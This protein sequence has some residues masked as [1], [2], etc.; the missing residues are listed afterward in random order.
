MAPFPTT[1]ILDM[2]RFF[3]P[4]LALSFGL[5]A[6]TPDADVDPVTD[7]DEPVVTD[8]E[9]IQP[10]APAVDVQGTIDALDGGIL[11]LAPSAAL[12]NING[13]IAQLDGMDGADDVVEGLEE[14]REALGDTPLDGD[15]IGE[16]LSELGEETTEAAGTVTG[17][18]RDGLMRLGE[19]LST[20][21][22]SL[23]S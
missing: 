23:D 4:I 16:I 12:D 13:W 21:G 11:D 1:D 15:Y 10:A 5:A 9:P 17:A 22:G 2:N 14:L 18:Q 7:V 3:L 20:A 19:L 6:C 8:I